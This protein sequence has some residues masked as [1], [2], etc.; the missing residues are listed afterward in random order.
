[1][2]A[3]NWVALAIFV[4]TYVL[5]FTLEKGRPYV[6]LASALVFVVLGII[7][8]FPDYS[9]GPLAALREI[10]WNVLMMIAGIMGT[11]VLFIDSG[12]PKLIS[13]MLIS[14]VSSLKWMIV[15]MSLFAGIVSAFVDNVATV[16]MIAP[17]ALAI[18]AKLGVSPVPMVICVSISSNLQG[19][20]TLV[21]DTTSILLAKYA[22]LDFT[23]FFFFRGR[24]GMFWVTEAGALVS[25]LI[26]CFMFRK[27]NN[28]LE[29]FTERTKV[30]DKFPGI[31]LAGT[32]V[33][34]IAVSFIPYKDAA[35][36]GQFYK[37]DWSNGTI[38]IL[39]FLVC[40]VRTCIKEHSPRAAKKSLKELD[41]YTI[42]LLAGLFIVIGGI[43]RAGIIDLIARGIFDL[44]GGTTRGALFLTFTIIVWMS[45]LVSAFIDNIPYVATMLPVVRSLAAGFAVSSDPAVAGSSTILLYFGLLVGATLGGN[46]TP[47][48]ASANV[49][50]IGLLRR[51]GY[52][53]KPKTF[54]KYSVPFTLSA[55]FVGYALLW[56]IWI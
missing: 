41:L 21:G 12:M 38:C 45:V 39:F 11:V 34:L 25:A 36:P 22:G 14:K 5:I 43:K 4:I 23:D 40:M 20:A 55:V 6:A 50:G 37:P 10:D 53:V 1:M 47:I 9:Y 49:Q 46:L 30:E 28:K 19:A 7:R 2:T 56:I 18:C 27:E 32:V 35:A 52:T 48:G 33:A 42:T 8:V 17:V 31:M 44:C 54:M 29:P 16:L 3:L 15:V 24:P 26:I 51:A 13:E